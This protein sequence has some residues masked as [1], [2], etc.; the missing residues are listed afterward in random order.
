MV[1]YCNHLSNMSNHTCET[2]AKGAIS[3]HPKAFYIN[4]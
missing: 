2:C 4:I 1:H 3:F